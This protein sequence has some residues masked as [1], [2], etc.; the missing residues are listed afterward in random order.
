MVAL[1]WHH[2]HPQSNRSERISKDR[3]L[4]D[5]SAENYIISFNILSL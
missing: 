2:F 5:M 1:V 4:K 3:I